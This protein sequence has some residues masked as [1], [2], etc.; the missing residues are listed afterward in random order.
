MVKN[1]KKHKK[2]L[3]RE[4]KGSEAATFDFFPLT[5]NLPS[6][7]SLFVEEFKRTGNVWIMKPIGKS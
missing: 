2:Q 7:Y 5:Y 3:E 6:D 4:G 1:L